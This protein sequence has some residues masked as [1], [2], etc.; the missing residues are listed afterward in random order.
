MKKLTIKDLRPIEYE[1][2]IEHPATSEPL[3]GTITLVG[4]ENPI[5]VEQARKL[6]INRGS[7]SIDDLDIDRLTLES[8]TLVASCIVGWDKEFFGM[9]YS[10]EAAL[11]LMQD[12][13][14]TWLKGQVETAMNIR[15][16][17]FVS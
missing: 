10:K 13:E 2:V 5:Y 14:Y 17:F 8:N 6:F 9:E 7:K 4:T 1:L 16:N 15:A 11:K 12:P 3:D